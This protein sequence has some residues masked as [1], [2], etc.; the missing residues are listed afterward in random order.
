MNLVLA[1]ASPRRRQLLS[2]LGIRFSVLPSDFSEEGVDGLAPEAQALALS[3]GKAHSVCERLSDG[4]ILGADTIVVIDEDV[5]GKPKSPDQAREMLRRLSGRS[6]R[7][8]TGLALFHVENGRIV[9]ETSG[10]EETLVYFRE[11]SEEDINRYVSTGDCLDKAGAYGIQG[12]AALLV[13]RLEG[14]YFNVVGLPLVRLDKLLRPWGISLMQLATEGNS[15][16]A[17]PA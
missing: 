6:H 11:L 14:D 15:R 12:L 10:Y 8:I 5:L 9:H 2:D 16:T 1:S 7:V 13:E 3:R 4:I 17:S